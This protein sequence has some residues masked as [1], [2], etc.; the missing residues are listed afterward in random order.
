MSLGPRA[1]G[2]TCSAPPLPLDDLRCMCSLDAVTRSHTCRFPLAHTLRALATW[3]SLEQLELAALMPALRR[4]ARVARV[5]QKPGC[6]GG[7]GRGGRGSDGSSSDSDDET[8]PQVATAREAW[9]ADLV[10]AARRLTR[11]AVLV[12]A[13]NVLRTQQ[14]AD[15]AEAGAGVSPGAAAAAAGRGSRLV[16][17]SEQQDFRG[18]SNAFERAYGDHS[19]RGYD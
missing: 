1:V 3:P 9:L 19:A 10:A 15:W 4:A 7:T 8:A 5:V 18:L 17:V 13:H 2:V 6:P 12:T 16:V 11:G 14:A